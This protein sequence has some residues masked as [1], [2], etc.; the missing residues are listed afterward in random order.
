MKTLIRLPNWIGDAVMATPMIR[1]VIRD[2]ST[3]SCAVWGPPK[4]ATLFHHFPDIDR[5]LEI[6]SKQ[7][8]DRLEEIRGEAFERIY[9][10]PNSYSSAKEAKSLEIP[11][12]IGYRTQWRGSLLTH[13][14][15]CGSRIRNLRMAEYYLHLLPE[16][17]RELAEG[18]IP[19]LAVSEEEKTSIQEKLGT[20]AI[21]ET[22]LVG[23]AP[24]AAFGP[25]KQWFIEN[26]QALAR[27]LV[28]EAISIAILGGPDEVEAG[29]YILDGLPESL[30]VNLAGKTTIREMMAALVHCRLVVTN[31]SGP[32]HIADALGTPT[33][34]IF[35]STDSSW[36]GPRRD[37]H[38]VL[39]SNAPCNPCFLRECPIG[40]P[41]MKGITVEMAR[42]GVDRILREGGGAD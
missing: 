31:D 42:E 36:T 34:A 10:L 11:E 3:S 13:G 18:P 30:S 4:V 22:T 38:Q 16:A 35:G 14:V 25:A 39:Q 26:F 28:D 33:V 8:P 9:L 15:W 1:A 40:Y 21:G 12:R 23:M 32:M 29:E 20:I 17:V 37:H 27:S 24:G 7:E 5:V 2:P 6:D 19:N 41:C